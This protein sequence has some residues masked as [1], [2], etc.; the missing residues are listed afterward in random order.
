[1]KT[2]I[3]ARAIIIA[4]SVF[5]A[6]SFIIFTQAI[7]NLDNF[8]N[9]KIAEIFYLLGKLAGLTGF[10]FLALLIFSG[11]T[12]RFFDRFFGLSKIIK[13]QRKF[14]LLTMI[15]I[16]A[17]PVFFILSAK[18]ILPYVIPDFSIIPLALGTI[19]FYIFIIVM[20]ASKMYKRISYASWQFIHL[21]TYLLFFFSSYH[22]YNWGFESGNLFIR[23]IYFVLFIAIISGVIYRTNYKIKRR[24]A[25]KFYVQ[26]VKYETKDI[27]TLKLKP[28]K[29][30][31]FRAGQFCFLRL[32]KDKLYARHPFTIA[33]S[34]PEDEICFTVKLEG[35]FT[36][37]LAGL[38]SGEE[39]IIEGPFGIFT[40]EDRA[41]DLVF[42]A[43]GVGITPFMSI[44]R[45]RLLENKTQNI[46]LLYGVKTRADIIY[47]QELDK[48]KK[49]WFKKAYV[50]SRDY[51]FFK[52]PWYEAGHISQEIIK[53]HVNNL[54]NSLFY[55][56]GPEAMKN[57]LK[58]VLKSLGVN[59]RNIMIEDFFW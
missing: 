16:L 59:K 3:K 54:N 32:A 35:K 15:F 10:L 24:L 26:E 7:F 1:M 39:V 27:F 29:K 9:L 51:A 21:L 28:E 40:P 58:K 36:K 46:I 48:I 52:Q 53:K 49:N 37:A 33:S 34:P 11:D 8:Q 31:F 6:L 20:I 12:A 2:K 41:K 56:C 44:I 22:A 47:R 45:D 13:F 5:S 38:K 42:M 30:F 4:A 43:G 23:V 57:S 55:V 19:S 14:S 18:S 17:H 50:L 25:G